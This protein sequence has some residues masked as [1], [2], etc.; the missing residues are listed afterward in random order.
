MERKMSNALQKLEQKHFTRGKEEKLLL[1]LN[2]KADIYLKTSLPA[3]NNPPPCA[4]C[5]CA[6]VHIGK[7]NTFN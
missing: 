6:V 3:R 2:K 7:K 5:K 1:F 4:T